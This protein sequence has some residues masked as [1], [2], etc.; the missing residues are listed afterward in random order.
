MRPGGGDG[1][2]VKITLAAWG[3][4]G[5]FEPLAAIGREL[6]KREHDVQIAVAPELLELAETAGISAVPYG[7]DLQDIL[8]LYR[9]YWTC[10]FRTPWKVA[11]LKKLGD[12]MARSIE[13]GRKTVN[14]ALLSLADGSDLLLTGMN[15]E[16]AASNVA[17][18]Y[19]IP[20]ATLHWFPMRPNTQLLPIFS[21]PAMTAFFW[22]QWKMEKA[23]DQQRLELGLPKATKPSAQRIAE[24]ALEIQAY[25]PVCFPGLAQEWDRPFVGSL[26][27][28]LP[29]DADDEVA[30]WIAGKPPIFFGFGSIPV[31]SAPHTIA[32]IQEVCE[33]LGERALV[34]AGLSDFTVSDTENLK[35]VDAVNFATVFPACKAIVHHGGAG[36]MALALRAGVPQAILST[37]INQTLWGVQIKR[38]KLGTSRRFSAASKKNLVKDLHAILAPEYV[39]RAQEVSAKMTQPSEGV[40]KAADLV[41]NY[42]R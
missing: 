37:D 8:N 5:E 31:E 23:E 25:D 21:K 35:V 24:R 34:C 27:M 33:Q 22:A 4:R 6:L 11:T 9:D 26:A 40:A 29:T 10:L 38:L 28:E 42:A 14:K 20:L 3:S 13:Q 16:D 7:P 36:T 18:Y 30:S 39:R 15:Y 1:I 41:E 17:E 19:N 12:K 2:F 32:M